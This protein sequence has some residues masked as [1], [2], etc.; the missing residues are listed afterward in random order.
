MEKHKVYLKM[1]QDLSNLS[2][3][4][5][6][7]V[8]ALLV[9]DDRIISNGLNGTPSGFINCCDKFSGID[10]TIEPGKSMHRVWAEKFEIHSE[11][12]AMLFAAKSGVSLDG[13][14]LYCNL[15]PCYNCLKHAVTVG[16]REIYFSNK[17]KYNL[18]TSEALELINTLK[19]KINHIDIE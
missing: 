19:I 7:K 6:H 15:E 14:V 16:I 8:G 13:A 12:N 18:E 5:K 1:C 17:H 11:M 4:S 2:K 3:C 10:V 9:K